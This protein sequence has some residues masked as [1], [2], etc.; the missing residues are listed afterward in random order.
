[1]KTIMTALKK[2]FTSHKNI[3]VSAYWLSRTRRWLPGVNLQY[4]ISQKKLCCLVSLVL[5]HCRI[6]DFKWKGNHFW[7]AVEQYLGSA[8]IASRYQSSLM[9][10]APRKACDFSCVPSQGSKGLCYCQRTF[11]SGLWKK[12]EEGQ[13]WSARQTESKPKQDVRTWNIICER[14]P[15]TLFRLCT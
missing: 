11:W 5:K 2:Q 8:I 15:T 10:G 9:V 14:L 1:M 4:F 7:V 3:Q 12:K 6:D 13:L